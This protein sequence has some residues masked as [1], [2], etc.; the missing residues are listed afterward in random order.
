[1]EPIRD[2]LYSTVQG[3]SA[4]TDRRW[5]NLMKGQ[6]QDAEVELVAELGTAPATVEQ[7]LSMRPGDFIGLDV[8]PLIRAK[9]DG[10]P[11]FECQYGTNNGRYAIRV[12]KMLTGERAGWL[13]DANHGR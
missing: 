2:I 5:V 13:G 7:L 10:V 8:E 9:V 4:E 6:I 1:M 12:E 11:V 3:D